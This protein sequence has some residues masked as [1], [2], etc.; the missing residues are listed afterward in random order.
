LG[1]ETLETPLA[2]DVLDDL[3]ALHEQIVAVGSLVHVVDDKVGGISQLLD[4]VNVDQRL[5][6]L[7]LPEVETEALSVAK[8]V[9]RTEPV[10]EQPARG[11]RRALVMLGLVG[12]SP[13]PSDDLGTKLLDEEEL[14]L[15][16]AGNDLVPALA[17]R[18]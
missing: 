17:V 9:V 4:L 1:D 6:R 8:A 15:P 12:A 2:P 16:P 11:F 7:P 5:D 18:H 10:V 13:A 3:L 14:A